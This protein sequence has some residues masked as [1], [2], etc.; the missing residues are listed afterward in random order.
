MPPTDGPLSKGYF[1][2]PTVFSHIDNGFNI[3]RQE[4]FGPVVVAIPW[5]S[6][7]EVIAM[8]NDTHYGLSAFV[9][10]KNIGAAIRTAHRIDA[11]WV[12]VNHG[13]GQVLGQSYGGYKTSGMGREFSLE[14]M[15]EAYTHR[16]HI[17]IN[18]NA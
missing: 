6:E 5:E 8:A 16:K 18:L 14:G 2:Q 15:L 11:G 13:G 7:D 9:H 3:N 12:Q 1:T 4:I 17:S 10:T